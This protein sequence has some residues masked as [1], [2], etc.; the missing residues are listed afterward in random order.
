MSKNLDLDRAVALV[1]SMLSGF[2]ETAEKRQAL[3]AIQNQTQV[4]LQAIEVVQRELE[5]ET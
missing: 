4:K 2:K 5:N 1:R 3:L